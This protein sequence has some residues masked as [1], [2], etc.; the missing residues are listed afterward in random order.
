MRVVDGT[1]RRQF[2]LAARREMRNALTIAAVVVS[3]AVVALAVAVREGDAAWWVVVG[4]LTAEVIHEI[5]TAWV[6]FREFREIRRCA[7]C[8]AAAYRVGEAFRDWGE[9]AGAH[10]P[11]VQLVKGV[12]R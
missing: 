1:A 6:T 7:T 5:S 2:V 3:L 8:R 4:F 10:H 11:T 9:C 12:R